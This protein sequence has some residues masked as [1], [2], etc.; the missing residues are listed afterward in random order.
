M[1]LNVLNGSV[2]EPCWRGVW[3][4]LQLQ[5]PSFTGLIEFTSLDAWGLTGPSF[6]CLERLCSN[7]FLSLPRFYYNTY[8]VYLFRLSLATLKQ[9]VI[10]FIKLNDPS[11]ILLQYLFCVLLSDNTTHSQEFSVS[12]T[13]AWILVIRQR[14]I[15]AYVEFGPR[16]PKECWSRAGERNNVTIWCMCYSYHDPVCR[17]TTYCMVK[18]RRVALLTGFGIFKWYLIF[19]VL[20]AWL[21]YYLIEFVTVTQHGG[22]EWNRTNVPIDINPFITHP[23]HERLY[24]TTGVYAP[25][26]LRT[27]VWVPQES[28]QWKSCE[29]APT[30]FCPYPRRLEC[31]I[32]CRCHINLVRPGFEPPTSRSTDRRLSNWVNRA[33]VLNFTHKCSQV[34]QYPY[35]IKRKR[36][37]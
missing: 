32:N 15:T 37:W 20:L 25:Y 36:F 31:L 4:T 9:V 30:V 8:F 27:A 18:S 26:S 28:E 22:R 2:G 29:T 12:A 5:K 6:V 23:A 35:T 7:T 3:V 34:R 1:P 21:L 24:H 17:V 13:W 16:L 19:K 33:A 10:E 11:K 14:R